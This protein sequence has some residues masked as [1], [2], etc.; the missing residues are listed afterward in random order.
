M[1]E[2]TKQAALEAFRKEFPFFAKWTDEALLGPLGPKERINDWLRAC[3][4]MHEYATQGVTKA[5]AEIAEQHARLAME[6]EAAHYR[7]SSAV[8]NPA[9]FGINQEIVH[10]SRSIGQ[11]IRALAKASHNDATTIKD[12]SESSQTEGP[13]LSSDSGKGEKG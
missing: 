9:S 6:T 11:Q 8:F 7:H 2:P 5:A 13:K 4:W 1:N 3:E 10:W 12:R